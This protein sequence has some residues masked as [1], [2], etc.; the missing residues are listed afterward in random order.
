MCANFHRLIYLLKI[1][2][3][4]LNGAKPS[5]KQECLYGPTSLRVEF[6]YLL[7]FKILNAP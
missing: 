1:E 2:K 7:N 5:A 3:Q 6:S 4:T